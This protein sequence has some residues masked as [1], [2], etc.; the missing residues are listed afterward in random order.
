MDARRCISYLTIELRGAIPK[1]LRSGIGNRVFGCDI[2][3]EVCPWNEQFARP[4]Q[5]EAYRPKTE[6]NGPDLRKLTEK[7]LSLDEAGFRKI[8]H[9]STLRPSKREG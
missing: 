2:C 1:D 5:E 4:T 8:F 7:L 9:G 3:Q 6:L